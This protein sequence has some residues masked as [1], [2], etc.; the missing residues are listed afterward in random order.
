MANTNRL[1]ELL[2]REKLISL[3]QLRTAQEEQQ[4]SGRQPWLRPGQARVHLRRRDHQLPVAAV[5]RPDDRPRRLRDRRRDPEAGRQGAVREAPGHPRLAHR[6]RAHR[7]DGRPDQPA[8]HRRPQVPDRLQHRAGH[9][10]RDGD[11]RD[12][13]EVLQRRPL[14]RRGHG[15]LRGRGD[16]LLRRRA[17]TSTCSSSRRRARTRRSSAS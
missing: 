6:Q 2:V 15:R 16:R 14:V 1:G 10:E 9:R 13:R 8:R 3:S 7:R 5:P 11:P 17:R 12:H 4:K